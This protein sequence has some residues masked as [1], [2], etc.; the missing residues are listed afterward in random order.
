MN[1][2][3]MQGREIIGNIEH[4]YRF[5]MQSKLSPGND[6]EEFVKRAKTPWQRDESVREISHQGLAFMHTGHFMQLS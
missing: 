4:T 3:G 2:E 5:A 1:D 6:F